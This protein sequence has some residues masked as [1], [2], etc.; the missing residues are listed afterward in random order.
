M[1]RVHGADDGVRPVTESYFFAKLETLDSIGFFFFFFC[2]F[3][4]ERNSPN[5][6]S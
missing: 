1:Y 3:L 4:S 5:V 6:F 2:S